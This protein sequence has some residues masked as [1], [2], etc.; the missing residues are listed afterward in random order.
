MEK[1]KRST[2][3]LFFYLKKNE[4]KK[5][6]N[7]PVM[8]RITIVGMLKSFSTKLDIN[9]NNWDLKQVRVLDK[10]AQMDLHCVSSAYE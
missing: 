4:P 7:V 10:S 6:G 9:P 8:G 3:K 5:N 1:G 2:F